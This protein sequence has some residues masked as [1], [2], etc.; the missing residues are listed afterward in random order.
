[1]RLDAIVVVGAVYLFILR[2]MFLIEQVMSRIF[3]VLCGNLKINLNVVA[4][5]TPIVRL[6]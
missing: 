6:M 5:H 3:V 2:V 1:V 4:I